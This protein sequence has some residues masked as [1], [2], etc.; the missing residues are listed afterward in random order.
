MTRMSEARFRELA[1]AFGGDLTKWPE[2]DRPAAT[3]LLGEQ[4]RLNAVLSE[5]TLFDTELEA[6]MAAPEPIEIRAQSDIRAP[7][8]FSAQGLLN[9]LW[10]FG[11]IW[12]PAAGLVA[13]SAAGFIFGMTFTDLPSDSATAQSDQITIVERALGA[14]LT[15]IDL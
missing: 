7:A 8:G 1:D 11:G 4:P 9:M 2:R 3:R 5:E 6:L 15:E 14:D 13:A 10:P 12:Q